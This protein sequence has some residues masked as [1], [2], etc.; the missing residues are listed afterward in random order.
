[1]RRSLYVFSLTHVTQPTALQ[2]L[3]PPDSLATISL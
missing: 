3:Y 1:V 2:G